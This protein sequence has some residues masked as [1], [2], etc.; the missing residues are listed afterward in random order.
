[1]SI[2]SLPR[3]KLLHL[4][5]HLSH[6]AQTRMEDEMGQFDRLLYG[7]DNDADEEAVENLRTERQMTIVVTNVSAA[8]LEFAQQ[9]RSPVIPMEK[10]QDVI[11]AAIDYSYEYVGKCIGENAMEDE[12]FA[13]GRDL[14]ISQ[15]KALF[16]QKM[17]EFADDERSVG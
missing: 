16:D 9:H 2:R 14:I 5:Q 11:D 10:V 1:M 4:A 13:K 7:M 8:L 17:L 6:E 12:D 3:Q 15:W